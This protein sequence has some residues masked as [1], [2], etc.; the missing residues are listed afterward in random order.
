[1]D[2]AIEIWESSTIG[3]Q[4]EQSMKFEILSN[5]EKKKKNVGESSDLVMTHRCF[6]IP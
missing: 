6:S 4:S 3:G 2:F 1:M 5:D